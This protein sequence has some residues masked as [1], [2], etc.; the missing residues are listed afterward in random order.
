MDPEGDSGRRLPFLGIPLQ[1]YPDAFPR[2]RN[3]ELGPLPRLWHALERTFGCPR[4]RQRS[5]PSFT[6]QHHVARI[7]RSRMPHQEMQLAPA[8]KAPLGY[9]HDCSVFGS[10]GSAPLLNLRAWTIP[11]PP[12]YE[13]TGLGLPLLAQS[14]TIVPNPFYRFSECPDRR[15]KD[16]CHL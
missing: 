15:N 16:I 7:R 5:S 3:P 8:P 13:L 4:G 6:H 14:W 1:Y 12:P 10:K 11:A 2:P 9:S